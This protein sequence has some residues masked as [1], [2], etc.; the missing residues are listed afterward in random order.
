MKPEAECQRRL[1]R[2]NRQLENE[3][4]F[5]KKQQCTLPG[6]RGKVRDDKK[7]AQKPGHHQKG[8]RIVQCITQWVLWMAQKAGE[9]KGRYLGS[10]GET[11]FQK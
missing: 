5:L 3:V 2:E 7:G 4:E 8:L 11:D 10:E 9:E 1:E 6:T